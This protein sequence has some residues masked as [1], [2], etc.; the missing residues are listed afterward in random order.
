[1]AGEALSPRSGGCERARQWAS[2]RVDG[3]L[4][5][6]E[7]TLLEKHLEG[8][9]SCMAFAARLTAATEAV[10]AVPQERP[11]IDYPRFKRPVIRLPVGRRVA[12]VAVAAA[13]VLGAFVG[14]SLQKPAPTQAPGNGPQFSFRTDQ[15]QLRQLHRIPNVPELK[16]APVRVP[17]EP[18]EG[19]I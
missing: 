3:E 6:L 15:N 9:A 14:S 18:P 7:D 4:S 17:G 1:M 12:I 11:Q 13:A 8:C 2:L 16:P 19:V 10:R 5:E